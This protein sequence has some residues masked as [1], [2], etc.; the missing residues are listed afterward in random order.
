MT[1]EWRQAAVAAG[2]DEFSALWEARGEPLGDLNR[3]RGGWSSAVR[4]SLPDSHIDGCVVKRQENFRART[5]RHPISGVAT[6][7]R[8]FLNLRRAAHRGLPVTEPL[9]FARRRG[10]STDQAILVLRGLTGHRGLNEWFGPLR[11][12]NR[13]ATCVLLRQRMARAAGVLV[14]RCHDQGLLHNCLYPKH[15]MARAEGD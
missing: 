2:L 10:D 1:D 9:Y 12:E 11:E 3:A 5:L 15:L 7:A 8:E 14:R 6:L 13:G 4:L